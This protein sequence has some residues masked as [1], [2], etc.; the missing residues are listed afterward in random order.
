MEGREKQSREFRFDKRWFKDECFLAKVDRIW[1]QPVRGRDSLS[2]FQLKLKNV[3][4]SLRGWGQI[5]EG[6][7]LR[8]KK[9]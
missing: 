3:K 8:E 7:I 4:K 5:S 6:G 9:S 2:L 1:A